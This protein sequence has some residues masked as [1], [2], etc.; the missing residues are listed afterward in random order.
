[1]FCYRPS[2]IRHQKTHR[3][4]RP[5]ECPKCGKGFWNRSYLF[6]HQKTH[7]EERPFHCPDCG[8]GFKC[9]FILTVH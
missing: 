9:N 2:L 3:E 1:S 4:E 8:K 6:M 7:T 5:Y